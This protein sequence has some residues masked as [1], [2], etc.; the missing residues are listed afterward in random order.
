MKSSS[1]SGLI[2]ITASEERGSTRGLT[3]EVS[4]E[5]LFS[6]GPLLL[7]NTTIRINYNEI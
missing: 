3:V 1:I 7:I 4:R 2:S 5:E 6:N